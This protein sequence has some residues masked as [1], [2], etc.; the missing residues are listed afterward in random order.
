M[1]PELPVTALSLDSL[2]E[3][4]RLQLEL[5]Q[6]GNTFFNQDDQETTITLLTFYLGDEWYALP[7][8]QVKVVSKILDITPVPGTSPYVIGVINHKS[9]IYPLIDMHRLLGLEP[10]PVTRSSRLII[11]TQDQVSFAV[12]VDAMTDVKQVRQ[13]ALLSQV[14]GSIDNTGFIQSEIALPEQLLGLLSL[15]NIVKAVVGES[16]GT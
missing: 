9:T 16:N 11:L 13:S 8:D 5:E 14:R 2:S 15:E 10:S 1:T 4:E 12:L 3:A 6:R 7:L